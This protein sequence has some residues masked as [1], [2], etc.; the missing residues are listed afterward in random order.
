MNP[1]TSQFPLAFLIFHG[2]LTVISSTGLRAS[3]LIPT[4]RVNAGW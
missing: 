2:C 3:K 4:V 1:P